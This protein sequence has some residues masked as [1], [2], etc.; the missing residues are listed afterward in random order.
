MKIAIVVQ[1][2]GADING[3]AELHARYIAERLARHATVEVL[4]TCAKDYITWKNEWPAGEETLN[5]ITI[6]RFPVSRPRDT[7]DFGRRSNF[8]FDH[9][10]SIADELSW[11]DSEGPCSPALIRHIER[12]EKDFDFFLFFS[13]RYYHAWHGA[14]HRN[15]GILHS[16]QDRHRAGLFRHQEPA[17]GSQGGREPARSFLVHGLCAL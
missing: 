6:R 12:V 4:T 5:K 14:R 3:G 13:A 8:V 15:Q 16:R 1:R 17:A 10:H 9:T 7:D 11:L 2:Y